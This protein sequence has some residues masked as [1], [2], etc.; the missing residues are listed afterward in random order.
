[1]T[2]SP[3]NYR[4]L[5]QDILEGGNLWNALQELQQIIITPIKAYSTLQAMVTPK[6]GQQ[7]MPERHGAP[8]PG[9]DKATNGAED[10]EPVADGFPSQTASPCDGES[11]TAPIAEG[12]I[13]GQ[14]TRVMG[15]GK[16]VPE[17][18]VGSESRHRCP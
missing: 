12:D 3:P 13:P 11:A 18:G 5:L 7:V 16:N 8:R 4:L 2:S 15:K 17:P 10:K 9:L 1:M 14:F 6:E